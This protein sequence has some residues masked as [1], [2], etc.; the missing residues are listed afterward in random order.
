MVEIMTGVIGDVG[1]LDERVAK[2]ESKL[3]TVARSM[4]WVMST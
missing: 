3:A 4:H 2:C 1:G